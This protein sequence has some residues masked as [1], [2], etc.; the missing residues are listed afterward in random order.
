MQT[1]FPAITSISDMSK[2][3]FALVQ[4]QQISSVPGIGIPFQPV[5]ALLTAL[6][7]DNA[8]ADISVANFSVGSTFEQAPVHVGNRNVNNSV[9]AQVLVSRS[10]TGTSG[11]AHAFSD[12][13][14]ISRSGTIGYNSFDGRVEFTG[15]ANFDHYTAFQV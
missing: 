9:D 11:N 2:V 10:I 3:R 8:T 13:S 4:G 7:S 14:D 15:T 5:A 1:P 12:S 6:V